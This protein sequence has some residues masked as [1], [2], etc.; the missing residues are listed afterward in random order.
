MHK[1]K[2]KLLHISTEILPKY[3][4]FVRLSRVH[5]TECRFLTKAQAVN[6]GMLILHTPAS[7]ATNLIL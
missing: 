1:G 2:K 5:Q 7:F 3:N 6:R 4:F